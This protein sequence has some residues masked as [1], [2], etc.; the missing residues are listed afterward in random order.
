[1]AR[2]VDSQRELFQVLHN[3]KAVAIRCAW[4]R[5]DYFASVRLNHLQLQVAIVKALLFEFA[6]NCHSALSD[7]LRTHSRK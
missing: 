5:I 2:S 3:C 4:E 1:M 6:L 7:A